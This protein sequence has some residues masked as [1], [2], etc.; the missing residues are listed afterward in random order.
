MQAKCVNSSLNGQKKKT[1]RSGESV[2]VLLYPIK[3]ILGAGRGARR[4]CVKS[5]FPKKKLA[6]LFWT[7]NSNPDVQHI[8]IT[9]YMYMVVLTTV[10]CYFK[11]EAL[12]HSFT[13]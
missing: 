6:K 1:R 11:N 7:A 13:A 2:N 10:L 8:T 5:H 9:A 3:F 4:V 12:S